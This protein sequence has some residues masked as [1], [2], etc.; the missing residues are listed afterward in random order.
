MKSIIIASTLALLALPAFAYDLKNLTAQDILTIG[1]G[2]DKLPREE[3]DANGLYARMQK[4]LSEQDQAAAKAA[5]AKVEDEVRKKIE[6]EKAAPPP[7]GDK[8]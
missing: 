7:D 5:N 4:Q 6:A 8:K 2:L 3:T 1:K